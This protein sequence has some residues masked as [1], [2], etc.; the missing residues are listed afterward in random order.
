MTPIQ[1]AQAAAQ[2]LA[3][4]AHCGVI[5]TIPKGKM[6]KGFPK[7]ELLNEFVRNGEV[8]RTYNFDPAKVI[9]W[10]IKNGMIVMTRTGD[11]TL[12]FSEPQQK[13]KP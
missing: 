9:A 8:G 5:L 2:A 6:P 1:M 10:L 4:P 3:Q 12:Q 7:G 13:D 11:Q